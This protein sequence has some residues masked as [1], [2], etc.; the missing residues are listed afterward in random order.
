MKFKV[1]LIY[2]A[3]KVI[4]VEAKSMDRAHKEAYNKFMDSSNEDIFSNSSIELEEHG[5]ATS[6]LEE[7]DGTDRLH[8]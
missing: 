7:K 3:S 1:K 4:V 6:I 2:Q 5:V 8:F